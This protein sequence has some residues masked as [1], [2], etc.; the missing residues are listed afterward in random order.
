MNGRPVVNTPRV[1]VEREY[2][3][4][5]A[6]RPQLAQI[7]P[8]LGTHQLAATVYELDRGESVAPYHYEHGNEEWLLVLEG[9][10]TVRHAE[11]EEALEPGDVVC[12]RDGPAGAHKISN[13]RDET[14]RVVM[15][16]TA[17]EPSVTVYP[18]D[19]KL[20]VRPPGTVFPIASAVSLVDEDQ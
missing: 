18:D 2:D 8:S 5:R 16:S 7:G 17:V 19:G 3:A 1:R 6:Y 9:R 12:F 13:W 14:V 15:V 20:E 11:G 10:P 4:P